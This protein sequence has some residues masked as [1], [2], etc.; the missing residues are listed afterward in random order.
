M[1]SNADEKQTSKA[2]IDMFVIDVL[3]YDIEN[4][5]SILKLLNNRSSVGWR[6]AW[7]HDFAE[8]EVIQALKDL[9]KNG[10]VK[11]LRENETHKNIV[12]V[13]ED[14]DIW[15][16]IDTLWFELTGQGW[17]AWNNWDNPPIKEDD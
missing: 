8:V 12:P 13:D 14:E 9:I 17:Q 6:F 2:R 11:P 5:P 7:P 1:I 15:N 4:I 10:W 3:R 16:N